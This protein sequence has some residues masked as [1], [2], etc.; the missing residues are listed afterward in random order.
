MKVRITVGDLEIRTE[1]LQL[2]KRQLVNL[3]REMAGIALVTGAAAA[4]ADD[5][6]SR[7]AVGFTAHLELDPQRNDEP[8]LS[9]WFEESP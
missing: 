1:G 6:D 8:D 4:P 5:V 2:T 7:A 9:E 3:L